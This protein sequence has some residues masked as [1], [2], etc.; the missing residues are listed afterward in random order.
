MDNSILVTEYLIKKRILITSN[1]IKAFRKVDRAD[2]V[3]DKALA[4][5]D[6]PLEIGEGQTISQP[7]T[8]AFMFELLSPRA[9]QTILDIGS[10]SGW[11]TA[12]LAEIVGSFGSVTGLEIRSELVKF[13]HGNLA[14]YNYPHAK[15]IKAK[16]DTLGLPTRKFDRILVSASA[17]EFPEELKMQLKLGGILVIPV[18]NSIYKIEKLTRSKFKTQKYPGF[19]FV[20]LVKER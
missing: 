8:V 1:I 19:V 18:H 11:T 5:L 16:E 7:T 20:P 2:F 14:K 10:G 12:L 3:K 4:Y 6:I 17:K 9:S 13:G 15:I